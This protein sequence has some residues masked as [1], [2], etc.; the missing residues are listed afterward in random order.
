MDSE[1]L[2]VIMNDNKQIMKHV[3]FIVGVPRVKVMNVSLFCYHH[4]ACFQWT[5]YSGYAM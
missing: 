5:L 4:D 2:P 1:Y 3:K